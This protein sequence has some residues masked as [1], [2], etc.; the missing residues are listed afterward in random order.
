LILPPVVPW[1][2]LSRHLSFLWAQIVRRVVLVSE[3]GLP[4]SS[5]GDVWLDIVVDARVWRS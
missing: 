1:T 3:G 4:V 5:C 2:A